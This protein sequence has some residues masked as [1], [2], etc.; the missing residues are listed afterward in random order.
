MAYRLLFQKQLGEEG[1]VL[2]EKELL[3]KLDDIGFVGIPNHVPSAKDRAF[4]AQKA[5]EARARYKA[6]YPSHRS[7][8]QTM[9]AENRAIYGEKPQRQTVLA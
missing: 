2:N 3:Y 4:Y 9:V 5:A 8:E 6:T 7:V 1:V